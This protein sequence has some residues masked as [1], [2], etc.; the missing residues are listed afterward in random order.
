MS[1][2]STTTRDGALRWETAELDNGGLQITGEVN[3]ATLVSHGDDVMTGGGSNEKLVL[4]TMFGADTITDFSSHDSGART[5]HHFALHG[6]LR[7]FR[8]GVVGGDQFGEQRVDHRPLATMAKRS[9]AR[10][11]ASTSRRSRAFPRIS[12]SIAG[13]E[14]SHYL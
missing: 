8:R 1:V 4:N 10:S 12:S 2:S 14:P 13:A 11:T 6:G 5:R 9:K 7:E 3:G